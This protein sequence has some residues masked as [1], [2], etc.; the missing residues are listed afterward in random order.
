MRSI[1]GYM[2]KFTESLAGYAMIGAA[3]VLLLVGGLWLRK[4]VQVKF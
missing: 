2:A 1:P 4:T 3:G